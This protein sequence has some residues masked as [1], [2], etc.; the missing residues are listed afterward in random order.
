FTTVLT[1]SPVAI[2]A[3]LEDADS[4]EPRTLLCHR[5]S[6]P[7]PCAVDPP[8]GREPAEHPIAAPMNPPI[9]SLGHGV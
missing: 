8:S 9:T 6:I 2:L 7:L 1:A 4:V 3:L 5:P